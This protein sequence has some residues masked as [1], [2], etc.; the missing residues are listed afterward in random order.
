MQAIRLQ[1]MLAIDK[2]RTTFTL[3]IWKQFLR[4]VAGRQR[5][6]ESAK[7]LDAYLPLR[8]AD[9]GEL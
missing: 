5:E 4:E 2:P 8:V 6:A 9:V 3:K 7:T 1:E